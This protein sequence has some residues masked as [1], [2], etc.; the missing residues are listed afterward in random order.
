MTE[1]PRQSQLTGQNLKTTRLRTG[2]SYHEMETATAS[3]DFYISQFLF[4]GSTQSKNHKN[5]T[6]SQCSGSSNANSPLKASVKRQGKGI[7]VHA[8]IKIKK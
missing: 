4:P 6:A 8:R 3:Q 2:V 1:H 7:R 5:K